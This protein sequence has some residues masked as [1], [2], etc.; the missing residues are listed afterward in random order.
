[1]IFHIILSVLLA[2]SPPEVSIQP[3]D[4]GRRES[5]V[6]AFKVPYKVQYIQ[7]DIPPEIFEISQMKYGVENA[8]CR[9][10]IV[11]EVRKY[12]TLEEIAKISEVVELNPSPKYHFD[13]LHPIGLLE[14]YK[15]SYPAQVNNTQITHQYITIVFEGED[16]ARIAELAKQC[17]F[18]SL[19]IEEGNR[20]C[21]THSKV[22]ANFLVGC[23]DRSVEDY[24]EE[25]DH[26]A[27]I[28]H[29][30]SL[31]KWA[32]ETTTAD[33]EEDD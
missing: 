30:R 33:E 8:S 5:V 12:K 19:S 25:R 24:L 27:Y 21:G 9:F 10:Y 16:N 14:I 28:E 32:N 11:T 22:T 13:E 6:A 1:M 23:G 15:Q 17:R 7:L 29:V 18:R 20:I 3:R 2:P 26:K 31:I 4:N